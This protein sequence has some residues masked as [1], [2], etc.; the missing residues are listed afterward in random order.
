V[1]CLLST[2]REGRE[3]LS[4]ESAANLCREVAL[5]VH[6]QKITTS[7]GFI[8]LIAEQVGDIAKAYWHEGREAVDIPEEVT[9]TIVVGLCYLNWL[10][11]TNEK[12]EACFQNSLAKL[13]R[14]MEIQASE[15]AR[16]TQSE[17]Y[18]KG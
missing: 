15:I 10:G 17:K 12:I 8:T 13:R 1:G 9:D 5:E 11:L 6:R 16:S 3:S 4:L 2:G 14:H 7:A 18:R